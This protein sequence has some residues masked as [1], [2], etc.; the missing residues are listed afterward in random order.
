MEENSIEQWYKYRHWVKHL[1]TNME[2]LSWL[3][4]NDSGWHPWGRGFDPWPRSVGWGS[5]VAVSCG[6]GRRRGSYP[7]LL[8]L[9]HRLVA[10]APIWP[11]AWKPPHAAGCGPE[12]KKK[13]KIETH[14]Y[15]S[16]FI[17]C[18]KNANINDR[19]R[20]PIF[21]LWLLHIHFMRGIS[22]W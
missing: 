8:W 12:K 1:N 20:S 4:R 6:V 22:M 21:C 11:L 16:N 18:Y 19:F 15:V 13:K 5:N 2:F 3:S 7:A 10:A 17:I 9:W 14:K